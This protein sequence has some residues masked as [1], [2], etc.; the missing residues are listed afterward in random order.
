MSSFVNLLDIIYPVNSIYQSFEATSPAETIGGTWERIS[1]RFIYGTSDDS[2][3]LTTDGEST[4]TLT[5][6]EMP[7]HNHYTGVWILHDAGSWASRGSTNQGTYNTPFISTALDW[8]YTGGGGAQQHA[9]AHQ[10]GHLAKDGLAAG[11]VM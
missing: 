3:L 1:S 5:V 6:N 8:P 2:H 11:Q 9:P 4:H 10:S 7:S